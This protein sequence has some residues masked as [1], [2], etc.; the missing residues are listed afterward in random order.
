MFFRITPPPKRKMAKM[1]FWILGSVF[2][3]IGDGASG[4]TAG[5]L[6]Y[7]TNFALAL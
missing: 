7:N 6:L 5:G 4:R 2:F 1:E 3:Y